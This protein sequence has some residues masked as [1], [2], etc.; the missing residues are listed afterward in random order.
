MV[1][2]DKV[3]E[4]ALPKNMS[5]GVSSQGVFL[6]HGKDKKVHDSFPFFR[7]NKW[8][9]PDLETIV[10]FVRDAKNKAKQDSFKLQSKEVEEIAALMTT[11]GED[12]QNVTSRE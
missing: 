6:V 7:I 4:A 1:L 8:E 12:I 11:I 10:L 9:T 2:E 3:K 5:M